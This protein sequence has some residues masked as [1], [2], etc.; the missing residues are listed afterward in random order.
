MDWGELREV[1]GLMRAVIP[2]VSLPRREEGEMELEDVV[3][4]SSSPGTADFAVFSSKLKA[5]ESRFRMRRW[6]KCRGHPLEPVRRL[7]TRL[8]N[9]P[10]GTA[11]VNK[12]DTWR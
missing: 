8:V 7:G 9:N 10:S 3:I 2:R 11:V 5:R 4:W 1:I 6:A 12:E